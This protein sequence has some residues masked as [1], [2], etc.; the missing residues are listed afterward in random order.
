MNPAKVRPVPLRRDRVR[1]RLQQ[2]GVVAVRNLPDLTAFILCPAN[3]SP[4]IRV[5]PFDGRVIPNSACMT[6]LRPAPTRP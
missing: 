3:H 1:A 2:H 6:S 4:P 5:A